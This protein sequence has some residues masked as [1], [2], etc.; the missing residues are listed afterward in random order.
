[1]MRP[2]SG[3][4]GIRHPGG[5]QGAPRS[6]ITACKPS[7]HADILRFHTCA[8]GSFACLLVWYFGGSCSCPEQQQRLHLEWGSSSTEEEKAAA[9]IMHT[10]GC[11]GMLRLFCHPS[12]GPL[13]DDWFQLTLPAP[14]ATRAASQ[15]G[16]LA[17]AGNGKPIGMS[18]AL[19]AGCRC[20]QPTEHP[21]Y[22]ISFSTSFCFS[23]SAS[24]DRPRL[25]TATQEAVRAQ[26]ERAKQS[27]PAFCLPVCA[28]RQLCLGQ[29]AQCMP[30]GSSLDHDIVPVPWPGEA[31]MYVKGRLYCCRVTLV[32]AE[33]L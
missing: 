25:P 11:D 27:R 22:A 31:S 32:L 7:R 19:P 29:T 9:G 23:V 12:M 16:G 26:V 4:L 33:A 28:N 10:S 2:S 20:G 15:A 18:G 21:R 30:G 24:C 17:L 6:A 1:M 14:A 8:L 13:A 3:S 5:P